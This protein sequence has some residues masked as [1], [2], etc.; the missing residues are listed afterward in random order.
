[1]RCVLSPA[2]P[3]F[4][5]SG[6]PW[7]RLQFSRQ[8]YRETRVQQY[9]NYTNVLG[10]DERPDFQQQFQRQPAR[11]DGTYY[12]FVRNTRAVQSTVVHFQLRN[13]VWATSRND[14]F[15]VH[16]NRVNH[17]SPATRRITEVLNLAGGAKG[18]RVPNVGKVTVGPRA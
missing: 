8:K 17:F 9:K 18:P 13:L 7:D 14:V 5:C 1:M 10:P 4:C 2:L 11:K 16:E 6:I 3:S 12:D 15:V